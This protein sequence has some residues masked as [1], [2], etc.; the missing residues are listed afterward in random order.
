MIAGRGAF[1]KRLLTDWRSVYRQARRLTRRQALKAL[2]DAYLEM[3]FG[4]KPL[5]SDIEGALKAF[6]DPRL[7]ITRVSASAKEES[8]SSPVR[9]HSLGDFPFT[10][11]S[12]FTLTGST[13]VKIR[14]GV[15]VMTTGTGRRRQ[16]LGLLPQDFVPTVYELVPW[17]FL[18]D[19]FT[20]LGNVLAAL[21]FPREDIAWASTTT[22]REYIGTYLT[23]GF[24]PVP[25]AYEE[26][27]AT[28]IPQVVRWRKKAV[29][30]SVGVPTL[31]T[32][33]IRLPDSGWRWAN[34]LALAVSRDFAH[35]RI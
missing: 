22:V 9:T 2:S 20:D 19:Y 24:E 25:A 34:M 1:F 12:D 5:V 10:F 31:P 15:K 3:Q 16:S 13:T 11:Y 28:F 27:N 21:T 33:T 7:E 4:W 35:L 8:A 26:K 17:S 30:R 6:R 23:A 32:V 18:V 29:T 14:G